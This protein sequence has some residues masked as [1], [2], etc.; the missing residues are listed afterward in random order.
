MAFNLGEKSKKL[1]KQIALGALLAGY[2]ARRLMVARAGNE[3]GK[4]IAN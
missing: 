1:V 2:I 3:R 4:K